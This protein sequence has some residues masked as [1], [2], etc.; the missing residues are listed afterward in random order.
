[1]KAVKTY[2]KTEINK[3]FRIKVFG[4]INGVK[5]NTLVGVEGL[6]KVLGGSLDKLYKFVAR[7]FAS[8]ADK[9]VCKVYGGPTITFYNK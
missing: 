9:C 7:A 2:S 8:M 6:L 1:M 4:L 5:V 3:N